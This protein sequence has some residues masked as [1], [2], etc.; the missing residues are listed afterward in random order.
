V[1]VVP[2]EALEEFQRTWRYH[3]ALQDEQ[4]RFGG[5]FTTVAQVGYYHGG[6]VLYT[7]Q[8][9]PGIWHERC[10]IAAGDAHAV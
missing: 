9:I 2:I 5:S 3:H 8:D 10:L 6:D 7:L 4:L 1:Q